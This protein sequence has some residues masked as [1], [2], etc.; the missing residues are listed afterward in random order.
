MALDNETPTG[1][2]PDQPALLGRE[3]AEQLIHF[4]SSILQAVALGSGEREVVDRVCRLGEAMVPGSIATVM[5][6]D[7]T[8]RLNVHA[9]PSAPP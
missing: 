7:D 6:L 8:H 4:Q 5:L 2:N 1:G 3:D 9:A